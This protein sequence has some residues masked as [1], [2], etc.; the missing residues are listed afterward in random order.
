MDID[1]IEFL[2]QE[3][4]DKVSNKTFINQENLTYLLDKDFEK[5]HQ[6]K[7]IGFIQIL[8]REYPVDLS[9]LRSEYLAY[10]RN[11]KPK[12]QY[13][14]IDEYYDDDESEFN[15]KKYLPYILLLLGLA[16]GIYMFSST[17]SEDFVYQSDLNVVKNS[18]ISQKAKEN[19]LKLSENNITSKEQKGSSLENILDSK[20][21][22][23]TLQ[24]AKEEALDIDLDH[25][26][27]T[28]FPDAKT[29]ES[30]KS[31][32]TTNSSDVLDVDVDSIIGVNTEN[33]SATNSQIY[34]RPRQKVWIGIFYLD[35][36]KRKDLLV[37]EE[38]KLDMKRDQLLLTGH[39]N[40]K[41]FDNDKEIKV[42]S[43]H[44]V[45]FILHN[46]K[47]EEISKIEYNRYKKGE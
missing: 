10:I 2:K 22:N 16:F 46:G 30:N 5:L 13:L 38:L 9:E 43:R 37:K 29:T 33:K 4:L 17:S 25:A 12:D 15:I 6:T 32:D 35:T 27:E 39:S 40:F 14:I 23:I 7:A 44:S 47:L 21:N 24:E 34:L 36:K 26:V 28:L 41:L 18:T 8:E 31:D 19:L 11:N 1:G 42:K 3:G 20:D 45:R